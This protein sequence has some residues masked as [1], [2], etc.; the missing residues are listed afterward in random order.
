MGL[1]KSE[2]LVSVNAAVVIRFEM[3]IKGGKKWQASRHQPS[4]WLLD[5][6]NSG[7]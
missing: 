3:F 2:S 5:H 1:H 6:G 4:F 7:S